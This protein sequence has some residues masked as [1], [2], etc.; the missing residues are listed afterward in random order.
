[1]DFIGDASRLAIGDDVS[2]HGN[3]Y[4]NWTGPKGR[5]SIGARS[6]I[7]QFCVLY[8][9][10]GITIGS[11]CAIASAV[12]IYSQTNQYEGAPLTSVIDQ[13]VRYAAVTIGDDV[14]IGAA[15]VVLPGV[16]IDDHAVV[17]AGAVVR[18]DVAAW[19]IV[20]GVPARVLGDRRDGKSAG[21]MVPSSGSDV[22][23]P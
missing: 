17:A 10:G 20:G 15:A 7:D 21:R 5:I 2:F 3:A 8:G 23:R 22:S 19:S 9:Q 1:M 18:E 4:V 14:W 11:R 12:V 16:T 6:H 13:P